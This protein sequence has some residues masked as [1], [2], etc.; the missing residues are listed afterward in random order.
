MK[1]NQ[2]T[3]FIRSP[4]NAFMWEVFMLW[5]LEHLQDYQS[6]LW[7]K[8]EK[9]KPTEWQALDICTAIIQ[10]KKATNGKPKKRKRL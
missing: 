8:H 6:R 5:D 7:S 9:L 2:Y 10:I 3:N 1:Q 4:A